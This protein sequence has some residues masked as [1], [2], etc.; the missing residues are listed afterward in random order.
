VQNHD[1]KAGFTQP[2]QGQSLVSADTRITDDPHQRT[3]QMTHQSL[4][5]KMDSEPLVYS[6]YSFF[7]GAHCALKQSGGTS[8]A[9]PKICPGEGTLSAQAAMGAGKN[10]IGWC[11][12]PRLSCPLSY[13]CREDKVTIW[14]T[15]SAYDLQVQSFCFWRWA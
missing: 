10:G 13:L 11:A 12:D 14:K 9:L 15:G 8:A 6:E 1:A 2:S 5:R 3:H 4:A 7:W